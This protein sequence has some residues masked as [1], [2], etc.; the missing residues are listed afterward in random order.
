MKQAI[1]VLLITMLCAC[2]T[3]PP[4]NS[5]KEKNDK[6]VGLT[7]DELIIAEGEPANVYTIE[8]GG[9]IF[10][11]FKQRKV[12]VRTR[13]AR[14]VGGSLFQSGHSPV[15]ALGGATNLSSFEG[16]ARNAQSAGEFNTGDRV[17]RIRAARKA[18]KLAADSGCATLFKI[19]AS[20]IIVGWSIEGE[21]CN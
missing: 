1:V 12:K 19:S 20:D 4:E 13:P 8:K 21:K 6:W 7:V 5:S 10:E 3:A 16:G 17:A 9:R 11:Y 18:K 15:D 2:G 14:D